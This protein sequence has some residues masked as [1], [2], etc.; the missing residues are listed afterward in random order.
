MIDAC[1]L[2]I[3]TQLRQLGASQLPGLAKQANLGEQ[4]RPAPTFFH[5][6]ITASSDGL[7]AGGKFTVDTEED[8]D[9]RIGAGLEALGDLKTI[10]IGQF[11]IQDDN[12]RQRFLHQHQGMTTIG[13]FTHQ[14]K[15]GLIFKGPA[16]GFAHA[17]R[18]ID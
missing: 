14:G 13:G 4:R 10:A 1:R 12:I 2:R 11:N 8:N 6:G 5:I 17:R 3:A 9:R 7:L 15:V 16:Q 18:I